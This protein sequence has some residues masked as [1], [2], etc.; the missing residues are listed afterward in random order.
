MNTTPAMDQ[1]SPSETEPARRGYSVYQYQAEAMPILSGWAIGSMV[2]G[3]LWL[4]SRSE[5]LKGFGSQFLGWGAVNAAI[6]AL[7]LSGAIRNEKRRQ[8]GKISP[9]EH[10]RQAIQ[11]ERFVWFN[12][13]LDIGYMLGGGLLAR[14]NPD[15]PRKQ[16]MGWGILLQGAFL[17]VW[18]ILLA[19]IAGRRR[20][21]T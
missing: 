19:S 11:F 2:S 9:A 21:G 20:R 18:D 5:R 16:G 15:E 1:N 13:L 14:R 10:T 17:F 6:A 4:T 8:E 3:L 7:G 12:A